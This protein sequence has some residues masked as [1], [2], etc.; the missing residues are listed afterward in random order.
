MDRGVVKVDHCVSEE[1]IADFFT[2]PLQGKRFQIFRDL[3]LNI[4]ADSTEQYRSVLGN[5]IPE[6]NIVLD[7]S[8]MT[9]AQYQSVPSTNEMYRGEIRGRQS[10]KHNSRPLVRP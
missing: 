3:I 9:R 5:K 6:E 2:K 8:A 7:E 1:M 4:K 10:I